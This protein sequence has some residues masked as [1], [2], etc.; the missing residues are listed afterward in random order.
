MSYKEEFAQSQVLFYVEQHPG[1]H[2]GEVARIFG[3]TLPAVTHIVDRL[4]QKGL[5]GRAADP[6]DRRVCVLRLTGAGQALVREIEALQLGA[7]ERVLGR[8]SPPERRSV[9]GGLKTLVDA[10]APLAGARRRPRGAAR[11]LA[12]GDPG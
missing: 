9:L 11:P 10:G 6:D 3:V 12:Q 5:V 4:A 8:L 2:V 7:L 1:C